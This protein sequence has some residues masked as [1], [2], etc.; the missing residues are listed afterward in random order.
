MFKKLTIGL[1]AATAIAWTPLVAQQRPQT[2]PPRAAAP[3][4]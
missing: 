2:A 1:A 3:E 4:E